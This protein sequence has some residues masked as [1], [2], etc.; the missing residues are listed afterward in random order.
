MS[1]KEQSFYT[2]W[3]RSISSALDI[4]RPLANNFA[5]GNSPSVTYYGYIE[6]CDDGS[7]Y[8]VPGMTVTYD[9]DTA[10]IVMSCSTPIAIDMEETLPVAQIMSTNA[11]TDAITSV[12]DDSKKPCNDS[13][14]LVLEF[15]KGE[16]YTTFIDFAYVRTYSDVRALDRW[17][18]NHKATGMYSSASIICDSASIVS[19]SCV[20]EKNGMLGVSKT[21]NAT[22]PQKGNSFGAKQCVVQNPDMIYV[23]MES[24]GKQPSQNFTIFASLNQTDVHPNKGE[25]GTQQR[26][27]YPILWFDIPVWSANYTTRYCT[28]VEQLLSDGLNH[29]SYICARRNVTEKYFKSLAKNKSDNPRR[30]TYYGYIETCDDGS[31]YAVPGMTVT[32]DLDNANIVMSCSTPI[33][34]DMEETLPVAQIMSTNAY[35]SKNLTFL[36]GSARPC[37]DTIP[38]VL[39]FTKGETHSVVIDIASSS[40]NFNE[41]GRAYTVMLHFETNGSMKIAYPPPYNDETWNCSVVEQTKRRACFCQGNYAMDYCQNRSYPVQSQTFDTMAGDYEYYHIYGI[42]P[43][44]GVVYNY[45]FN[46][47]KYRSMYA[48]IPCKTTNILLPSG[49]EDKN[50]MFGVSSVINATVPKKSYFLGVTQCVV[51][52]PDGLYTD[53]QFSPNFTIFASPNLTDADNDKEGAQQ[54]KDTQEQ[55]WHP[56]F[57]FDLPAWSA[58]YTKRYCARV[59][60]LLSDGLTH[61]SC[62]CARRNVSEKFFKGLLRNEGDGT[63]PVTT[64]IRPFTELYSTP[65]VKQTTDAMISLDLEDVYETISRMSELGNISTEVTMYV[66]STVDKLLN[67]ELEMS[68]SNASRLLTS[69]NSIVTNS[70]CDINFTGHSNLAVIR[71]SVTCNGSYAKNWPV[72]RQIKRGSTCNLLDRG[73]ESQMSIVIPYETVCDGNEN[74]EFLLIYYSF[75][76]KALFVERDRKDREDSC[77]RK[78]HVRKNFPVLSAQLFDKPSMRMIHQIVVN[79][80]YLPMAK[81]EFPMQMMEAPLHG[82]LNLGYWNGTKWVE[83]RNPKAT[84]RG[85]NYAYVVEH[86]TDFTLIVDGLEM[87]PILCDAILNHFSIL[88]NFL[89]FAGLVVLICSL[90]IQR[91]IRKPKAQRRLFTERRIKRLSKKYT[92]SQ[93]T[94][95]AL[96]A[97]FHMGFVLF[98]DARDLL[99]PFTC[100]A[101]AMIMYWLLLTCILVTTFQ[102]LNIL[103]I[104]SSSSVLENWLKTVIGR[105]I[106]AMVTFGV[107]T[108]IVIILKSTV[109]DF[110]DRHDYF[111]WIRPDYIL[112]AVTLPLGL[113]G[114]NA[115]AIFCMVAVRVFSE[116][117]LFGANILFGHSSVRKIVSSGSMKTTSSSCSESTNSSTNSHSQWMEKSF[118]LLGMQLMLGVPWEE[119]VDQWKGR[120]IYATVYVADTKLSPAKG[121]TAWTMSG[122]S[123]SPQSGHLVDD[124]IKTFHDDPENFPIFL[125]FYLILVKCMRD[126]IR[127]LWLHQ[128]DCRGR[129]LTKSDDVEIHEIPLGEPH[130]ILS[131]FTSQEAMHTLQTHFKNWNRP[132]YA[133]EG[134][135]V[136]NL[137]QRSIYRLK[138]MLYIFTFLAAYS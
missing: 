107:P 34:I 123:F 125:H 26:K 97:L 61:T 69:L 117:N 92:A 15:T 5:L 113:H 36:D 6:T 42:L 131:R 115:I 7:C 128:D 98:S 31:C 18:I 90:I 70:C 122:L 52:S 59:E 74:H 67:D 17:R 29:T 53:L 9:L 77:D 102:S 64:E 23:E 44:A 65:K 19:P 11:Y 81:I 120:C 87:D 110:F 82:S 66:L 94:Y 20:E 105:K 32:Y 101:A 111:C 40:A 46:V 106:I 43:W 16:T 63:T 41:R 119:T 135:A 112:P 100:Q 39:E 73:V 1:S 76:N 72:M 24:V 28:H 71:Q 137:S 13:I 133:V 86:L 85:N 55:K 57:W 80:G 103:K 58:N 12:L 116:G 3:G 14:L 56:I 130:V 114:L 75:A 95:F 35:R 48:S 54:R 136:L 132:G 134:K 129:Y 126:T 124:L 121:F 138:N 99:W 93:P 50:G 88:L 10:N 37:N 45:Y 30:V 118:A 22:V 60:Q 109:P 91:Y 108:T 83:V 21:I 104:L 68:P 25:E 127:S 47:R 49:I 8:A 96:L 27:W 38:L 79:G 62:I 84:I 51:Q 2:T 4:D 33:A 89:S 78:E